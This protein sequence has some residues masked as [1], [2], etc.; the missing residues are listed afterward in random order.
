MC[1]SSRRR[2]SPDLMLYQ[3]L[4]KGW[5]RDGSGLLLGLIVRARGRLVETPSRFA[6]AENRSACPAHRLG[7]LDSGHPRP[8]ASLPQREGLLAL[9]LGAPALLLPEPLFAEP[10][11]PAHPSPG[12]R[13]APLTA[14]LRPRARLS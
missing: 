11:Q 2:R 3:T 5:C 8:V 14:G 6:A 10:T 12:A 7:G 9:R 1:N 13:D 4:S